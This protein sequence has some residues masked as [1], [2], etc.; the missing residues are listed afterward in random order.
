MYSLWEIYMKKIKGGWKQGKRNKEKAKT[1]ILV[2]D[3]VEFNT[4]SARQRVPWWPNG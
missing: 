3:K 2:L 4:E 1:Q